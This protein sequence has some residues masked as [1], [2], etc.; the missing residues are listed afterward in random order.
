MALDSTLF[1]LADKAL[2][3][4]LRPQLVAWARAGVSKRAAAMLL[5]EQ[6]DGIEIS[7]ET[8]GRWMKEATGEAA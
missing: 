6:L 5:T 2:G 3:G 8:A 4:E 7:H 1:R